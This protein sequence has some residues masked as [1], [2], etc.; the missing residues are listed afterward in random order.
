MKETKE[1][2]DV[3]ETAAV[4]KSTESYS[5][6]AKGL[7]SLNTARG[8]ANGFKGFAFEQMHAADARMKGHACQVIN[9]NGAA[10][11][12]VDGNTVQL[13]MGYNTSSPKWCDGYN[14]VVVDKGN[15][16]LARK[17][18]EAGYKVEESAISNAEAKVVSDAMRME[19]AITKKSTAPITGTVV[20]SHSAGK[21]ASKLTAKVNVPLQA[22]ANIY[23]AITGEKSVEDAV[24]DTVVDGAVTVGSAYLGTAALTAATTAATAVGTAAAETA[25]GAAAVSTATAAGSAIAGTAVGG[26]AVAAAGTVAGAAE[27]A[28]ASVAAA[29]V[30]PV[31][32]VA[33]GIGF[34]GKAISKLF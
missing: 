2:K 4:I 8:G 20:S 29:P 16:Q 24:V 3:F 33:A 28:V 26:A 21:A 1:N 23:D 22:G 10:D 19:S 9:N 34:V 25:I 32:A 6:M 11:L 27:L 13:K 5:E 17:A 12:L 30:L 18:A 7:N 31:V 14:T 15:T